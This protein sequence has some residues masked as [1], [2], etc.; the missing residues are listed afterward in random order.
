MAHLNNKCP[1]LGLCM[2]FPNPCPSWLSA[3]VSVTVVKVYIFKKKKNAL[4]GFHGKHVFKDKIKHGGGGRGE[5]VAA[6]KEGFT[7]CL[8]PV[9]SGPASGAY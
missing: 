6:A 8:A 1:D 3:D 4:K 7:C 9:K 5:N 2:S